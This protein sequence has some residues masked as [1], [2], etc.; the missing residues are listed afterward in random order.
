[1]QTATGD[2]RT[3]NDAL[4]LDLVF[5]A[6]SDPTR[7]RIVTRLS[8][9]EATLSELAEPFD[10]TMPGLSKHVTVLERAGIVHK[11]R[12]GR[13]RY[14]RLLPEQLEAADQWLQTQ[15][16]FWSDRLDGLQDYLEDGGGAGVDA[17]DDASDPDGGGS[18]RGGRR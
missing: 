3:G 15:T 8:Q 6:L 17:G 4:D 12:V 7:R 11:W 18:G 10:L 13:S 5:G 14:C 1:M 16:R 2:G 9:G